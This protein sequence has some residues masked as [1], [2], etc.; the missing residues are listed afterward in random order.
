MAG[1]GTTML[2]SPHV[3]GVAVVP[4]KVTALVPWVEPKFAPLIV[5]DVAIGPKLGD[6]PLIV[7]ASVNVTPLLAFPPTV[8][9]TGPVMTAKPGGAAGTGTTMLLAPQVVGVAV[10]P[11]K[12]TVLVPCVVPNVVPLIVTEVPVGPEVGERLVMNGVTV[13]EIPLLAWLLT[14]TTTLPVVAAAGTGTTMLLALHVV[15]VA[16]VPL[17][18]TVLVP[19]VV[20]KFVPV[21]VTDVPTGP[22]VGDRLLITGGTVNVTA[23]LAFPPTVTTTGPV[24][25]LAG[26][27]TTMLPAPQVVGVAVVPL[28]VTVLVPCVVPNVVPLIVTEVPVGPEVGERLVICGVTVNETALLA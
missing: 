9:T 23:L 2:L 12:V 4:L 14:V 7:G 20:P 17:K 24:V 6:R 11:L 27:R 22:N 3:V 25:V 18:V 16:A 26:T 19:W 1:T 10:V 15:G 5:T 13:N 8:T 28:K 21:I